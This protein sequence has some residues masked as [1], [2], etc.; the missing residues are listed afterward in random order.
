MTFKQ[1]LRNHTLKLRE[2]QSNEIV[3]LAVACGFDFKEF[4]RELL[5]WYMELALNGCETDLY[6]QWAFLRMYEDAGWEYEQ[7]EEVA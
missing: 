1:W 3:R 7:F 2:Y 4:C 5:V 6:E